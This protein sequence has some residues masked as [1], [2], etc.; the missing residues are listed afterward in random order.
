[1]SCIDRFVI[2]TNIDSQD[3][4][5]F[6]AGDTTYLQIKPLWDSSFG[7][8]K[9]EDISIA[10]D[11]RIFVADKGNNSILVFD[12]NGNRPIGFESLSNLVDHEDNEI[13]PIDVDI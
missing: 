10:Q 3:A 13:V 6:G 9:P 8:D 2:P 4:G 12:Q 7:L 5:Q 1:M 11:G